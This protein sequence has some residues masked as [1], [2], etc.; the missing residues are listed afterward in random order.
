MVGIVPSNRMDGPGFKSQQKQIIF[1]SPEPSIASVAPPSLPFSVYWCPFTGVILLGHEVEHSLPSGAEVTNECGLIL[2]SLCKR[3]WHG[4]RQ[5][6][7]YV[8]LLG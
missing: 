4:K 8:H 1:S 5:L 6:Y 7:L 2:C 3:V